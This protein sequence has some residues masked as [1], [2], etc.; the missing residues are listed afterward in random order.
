MD[1][2]KLSMRISRLAGSLGIVAVLVASMAYAAGVPTRGD[3]SA[4]VSAACEDEEAA[5]IAAVNQQLSA[6]NLQGCDVGSIGIAQG[7]ADATSAINAKNSALATKMAEAVALNGKQCVQVAFG[8]V[9][10]GA[11]TAAVED[12]PPVAGSAG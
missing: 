7:L 11:G 10:D 3:V 8:A 4:L 5:C 6:V 9:V 1:C 2:G 12:T